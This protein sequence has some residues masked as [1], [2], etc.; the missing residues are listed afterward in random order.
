MHSGE[1]ISLGRQKTVLLSCYSVLYWFLCFLLS[2]SNRRTELGKR[3][4]GQG[5]EEKVEIAEELMP[6]QWTLNSV[7]CLVSKSLPGLLVT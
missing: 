2:M 7:N 1:Q 3:R 6:A 4:K 5:W